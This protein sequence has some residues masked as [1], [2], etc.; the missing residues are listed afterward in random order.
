MPFTTC[1]RPR[2]PTQPPR[3]VPGH[4]GIQESGRSGTETPKHSHKKP[5]F[6]QRTHHRSKLTPPV[7]T[8]AAM[9]RSGA[10]LT[11]TELSTI[12]S[13]NGA[14]GSQ[15][16][17]RRE[18]ELDEREKALEVRASLPACLPR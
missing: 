5:I 11:P 13:S 10:N 1:T 12:P 2:A 15:T 18:R 17:A 14:S 7:D 8:H 16:A 9:C 4:P 6:H 3:Q